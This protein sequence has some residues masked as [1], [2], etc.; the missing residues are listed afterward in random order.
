MGALALE[1]AWSRAIAIASGANTYSFTVMLATFLL[2]I[3]IGSHLHGHPLL[4]RVKE[5]VRFGA[6]LALIGVSSA[7]ISEL[8]PYLPKLALF[9]NVEVPG[10]TSGVRAGT[11][12]VLSFLVMV[13][14]CVLM[15]M[16]FP[17]AGEARA[18]LD[19][20]FGEAVGDLVGLNTIGAILGSLLAGFVLIPQLGLQR[21]MLLASAAYLGYGLLVLCAAWGAERPKQRALAWAGAAAS[22]PLAIGLALVLPRWDVRPLA[23]LPNNDHSLFMDA[24]GRIDFELALERTQLLYA[25]E[26]R[27][28]TASV[29]ESGGV[30]S[31]LI[32][33]KVVATDSVDDMEIEYLLGH[34]PTLLHPNPR[35]AAVI[36]L[37]AG[38]TLGGVAADE[39]IERI[40]VVEIEPAVRGAAQLF[41][42][43]HDDAL[44]DPRVE[45]V[46]QDGRNYMLTTRERFDVIAADP[47][48]PWAQG[49][50]YLFTTEYYDL[51]ARR[52]RAGGIVCQWLPLYELNA[53]DLKSVIA[54]FLENFEQAT[55]WQATG[56]LLLIGS[57]APIGVDLDRFEERLRQPRV[58]RQLARAGL[59]E[60]LSFLAEYAMDRTAMERFAQGAIVNT[61]DN[62]HLEFSSPLSIGINPKRHL[63]LIDS[64]RVDASAVV[65]DAG[66]RFATREEMKRVF[67]G[68]RDAKSRVLRAAPRWHELMG[69]PTPVGMRELVAHYREALALGPG[70][71]RAEFLLAHAYATLGVL[72]LEAGDPREARRLFLAAL[73]VDPGNT[74]ANLQLGVELNGRDLELALAHLERAAERTPGSV[75]AQAA[76]AQVLMRLERFDEALGRLRV[77]FALRPDLAELHRLACQC[78]RALGR[79][80][81]A[82]QE[83]RIAQELSGASVTM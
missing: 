73:E 33:G 11:T 47:I 30:R 2:G 43:L 35:V 49:A 23:A 57:D 61:D 79:F 74:P 34:L 14:P 52:L 39:S 76:L 1:V 44:S 9:L 16:A 29:I 83:C 8:M 4:A 10:V 17:L 25:R 40:V 69:S 37:G 26:G 59:D 5:S 18:R 67:E 62:L 19:L 68:L 81:E 6:V 70:Y 21:S 27:G 38:L 3:A 28:S 77:A 20:R 56:D 7:I 24:D 75:N 36:G 71:T 82:A 50:A 72:H 13:V 63:P 41:A 15:G 46:W 22:L 42:D 64:Y 53:D 78:L 48:H 65:R 32:N 45:L 54:A 80:L 55:I 51:L 66:T 60:P 12:F 31:V 58:A